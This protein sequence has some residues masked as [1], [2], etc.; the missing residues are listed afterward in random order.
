MNPEKLKAL[1]AASKLG[2]KGTP[3]RKVK[4]VA[5]STAADDQKLI[6]ALKK[7]GV[8]SIPGIEEVNFIKTD[9]TVL[10]FVNPQGC[11]Y[12]DIIYQSSHARTVQ[13][14]VNSNTFAIAGPSTIKSLME[15]L[16][17]II[18]HLGPE[19]LAELKNAALAAQGAGS[20]DAIDDT[21]DDAP[22]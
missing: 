2:G 6:S 11:L 14:A 22:G 13:A 7:V 3:R 5:K 4:A 8:Q 21:E 18:N 9:G 15:V 20:A 16:P 17:S 10:N 1:Q 19:G 12:M